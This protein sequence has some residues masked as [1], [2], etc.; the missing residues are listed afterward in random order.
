MPQFSILKSDG[1]DKK[2]PKGFEKF[3]K[4][5]KGEVAKDEDKNEEKET[6]KKE[7]DD[8]LSEEEDANQEA[9]K[10]ETE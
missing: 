7:Q 4:G 2:P 10:K 6:T 3:F 9:A 1:G 8:E 5:K